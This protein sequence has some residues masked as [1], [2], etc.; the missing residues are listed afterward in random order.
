MKRSILVLLSLI[1]LINFSSCYFDCEKGV[2]EVI[3]KTED[4]SGFDVIDLR[5]SGKVII[6]KSDKFEFSVETNGNLIPLL[7]HKVEDGVLEIKTTKCIS[8]Y[9]K[10]NYYI[11]MPELVGLELSGSGTIKCEDTFEM[12]DLE[13]SMSGSGDIEGKFKAENIS[14]S[15][16]GSGDITIYG[17]TEK[18]DIR[19]NGSGD[20]NGYK[21]K[22]EIT[23]VKISGSGDAE[24]YSK[25]KIN[26]TIAGSGD[27]KYKGSPDISSSVTGSGSVIKK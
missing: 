2:G 21:L 20:F 13:I 10:L 9:D 15:I 18:Q 25:D 5:G 26:A 19:I 6:T 3:T 23:D 24:V 7:S 4:L 1:A 12:D 8:N 22:A 16:S 11:S 27:V 14:S 17:R